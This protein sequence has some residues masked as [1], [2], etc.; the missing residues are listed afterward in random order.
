MRCMSVIA[1]YGRLDAAMEKQRAE[2][3]ANWS[4]SGQEEIKVVWFDLH[5]EHGACEFVGYNR[6]S[7]K[8]K[9]SPLSKTVSR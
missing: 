5:N 7:P 4:G 1:R 8:G 9:F 6:L 2:A 3:R